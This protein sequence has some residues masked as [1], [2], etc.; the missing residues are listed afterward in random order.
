MV[1]ILL[2]CRHSAAYEGSESQGI[3]QDGFCSLAYHLVENTDKPTIEIKC[4]EGQ[5]GGT[6]ESALDVVCMGLI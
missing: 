3:M 4:D 6:L 5:G 2:T 1:V